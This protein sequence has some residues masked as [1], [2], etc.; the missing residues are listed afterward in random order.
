M[1]NDKKDR[2]RKKYVYTYRKTR[3][4]KGKK[5]GVNLSRNS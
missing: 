1:W 5:G 4:E 2:D 3:D